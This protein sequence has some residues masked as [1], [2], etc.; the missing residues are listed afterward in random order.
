MSQIELER[1][2]QFTMT[3][4]A[5]NQDGQPELLTGKYTVH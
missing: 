5:N 2:K 3:V 1:C 4:V